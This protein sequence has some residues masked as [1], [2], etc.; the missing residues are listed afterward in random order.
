MDA[1]ELSLE[2]FISSSMEKGHHSSGYALPPLA[3]VSFNFPS[4]RVLLGEKLTFCFFVF[5][6]SFYSH[7]CPVWKFAG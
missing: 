5:F 7:T 6:F 3:G 2:G 1:D 4:V